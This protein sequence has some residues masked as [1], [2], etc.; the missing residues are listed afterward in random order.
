M[1]Y[2]NV[3]ISLF[4]S[5][6]FFG[7]S[8]CSYSFSGAS[9]PQHLKTISI[10]TFA[11]NSR[12]AEANLSETLTNNLVQ[13]FI[14]DNN[15]QVSNQGN[16]DSRLS[17][18]IILLKDETET[19]SG[20]EITQKRISIKV[21]ASYFDIIKNKKVFEKEFTS[22]SNYNSNASDVTAIRTEA[23]NLVLEQIAEDILLAVVARW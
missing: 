22:Y 14:D 21:K 23:I 19:I 9:V 8:A 7:L 12:S 3:K 20:S 11:D 18:K 17:G 15:L 10:E 6:I 5:A 4:L 1:I 2:K 13:K 16:S